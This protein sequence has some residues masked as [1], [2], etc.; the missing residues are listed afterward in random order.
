MTVFLK[1][2]FESQSVSPLISPP[3][4]PVSHTHTLPPT[5]APTA[6]LS[7]PAGMMGTSNGWGALPPLVAVLPEWLSA[8]HW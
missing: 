5:P 1:L 6:A 2:W 4:Y 8:E 7:A 3:L